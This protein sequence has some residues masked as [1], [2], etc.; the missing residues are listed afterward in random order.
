VSEQFRI[1][2][3]ASAWTAQALEFLARS[4]R[5][6]LTRAAVV[7]E[8]VRSKLRELELDGYHFDDEVPPARET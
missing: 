5:F 4:G 6:G 8:L 2:F 3:F 1:E 7:D